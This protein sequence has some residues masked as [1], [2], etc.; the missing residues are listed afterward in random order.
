MLTTHQAPSVLYNKLDSQGKKYRHRMD[1]SYNLFKGVSFRLEDLETE[2]EL[3]EEIASYPEIKQMWPVR[4]YPM[5]DD[6]IVWTANSQTS[7]PE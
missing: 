3:A 2:E 7:P 6:E 1:L 5:P 4:E